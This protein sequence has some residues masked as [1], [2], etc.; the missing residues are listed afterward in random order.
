MHFCVK[1]VLK[2]YIVMFLCV[3]HDS[4]VQNIISSLLKAVI[5]TIP[6]TTP[7]KS[8]F[9]GELAWNEPFRAFCFEL[10]DFWLCNVK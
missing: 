6:F 10:S 1:Y 9:K 5:E 8:N 3:K 4:N 7:S 2:Y